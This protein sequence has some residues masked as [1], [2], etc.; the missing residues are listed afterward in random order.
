MVWNKTEPNITFQEKRCNTLKKS[1]NKVKKH[2]I[3]LQFY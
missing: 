1:L 2:K 3:V